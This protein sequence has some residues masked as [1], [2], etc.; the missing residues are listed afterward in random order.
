M[1]RGFPP[2]WSPDGDWIAFRD[3][4]TLRVVSPD[5]RQNRVVSKRTWETYGWSK[6]GAAVLGIARGATGHFVLGRID[7]ASGAEQELA[8]LGPIPP[9]V[10]LVDSL[11]E[12]VYRGFSLH[13]DGGSFLTS[14]LRIKTQIYLM[15]DFDRRSRL[16]D[17]WWPSRSTAAR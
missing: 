2:R 15:R 7:V 3:G 5:G 9:S 14:V 12:F 10:G 16:A 1:A 13:P 17:R 8:D 11:N 6:D 4:D